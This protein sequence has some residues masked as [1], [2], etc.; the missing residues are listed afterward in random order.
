MVREIVQIQVGQCGN[1]IGTKFWSDVA[2]EHGIGP[3]GFYC[4]DSDFQLDR[5]NVYFNESASARYVPRSILVDL[6]PAALDSVRGGLYG[7][8]FRPDN[9]IF[10]QCSTGNNWARG[11]YTDG[12]EIFQSVL[13]A[14]RKEAERCDVLEAVQLE[15][16]L[17]GGTGSGLGS[18][19]L[20]RLRDDY[21]DRILC[22]Y[23]VFPSQKM[24]DTVV[25]PYNA[26][27]TISKLTEDSDGAFCVDNEALYNL[28]SR[29]L[30][31]PR[32]T[33][34]D[35]N[36][37][38]S[39]FMCGVTCPG[40]FPGQLNGGLGKLLLN[41]VPFPRLHFFVCGLA[42]LTARGSEISPMTVPGLV[43]GLFDPRGLMFSC[44]PRAG[45]Y[46][47][48][49]AQFRGQTSSQEVDEQLFKF[50]SH[51][52]PYFADWIPRNIMSSLCDVP[53]RGLNMAATIAGLTTAFAAQLGRID[54]RFSQMYARRVFVHWYIG[55]GMETVEFDECRSNLMDLMREFEIYEMG[56]LD[57]SEDGEY[58]EGE[59]A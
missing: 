19:L 52:T 22:T 33:F 12:A 26:T 53:P 28:C 51:N 41:L 21:S 32:P 23:S 57:D 27:F 10:G 45:M 9:F 20:N 14:L 29:N 49:S 1:Q 5:I 46:Y 39:N 30:H 38:V 36:H 44:D 11:F 59:P 16:S 58:D 56:G 47:A 50:W 7:Q 2:D 48:V 40:R 35:M 42:P 25:E 31:L 37:L 55:E 34:G 24:S 18:L 15:H 43:T 3:T 8:L 17:G 6:D 54:A 4:G 13:D